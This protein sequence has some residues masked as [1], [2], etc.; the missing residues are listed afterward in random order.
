MP[1]SPPGACSA[2]KDGEVV[3]AF[4]SDRA[5]AR[6]EAEKPENRRKLQKILARMLNQPVN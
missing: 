4:P 5:A 6:E 3:I 2:S 1:R